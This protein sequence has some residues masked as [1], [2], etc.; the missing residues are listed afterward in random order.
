MFRTAAIAI[1]T[2]SLSSLPTFAADNDAERSIGTASAE[3]AAT[4]TLMAGD[5]DWSM[6]PV[7]VGGGMKRPAALAGLYVSLA[8]LQVYDAMSTARGM[9]QGAREANPL[10]QGAVNNSAMFW[11]I[12]AATTALPMVMAERMWKRN[13]VGAVVMMAVANSVAATVAANNARVLRAG[14]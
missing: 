12:K 9:K 7:Q 6:K 14:R 8:G 3:A 11:S 4:G 13:K 5:V 2:F 10:M 1:L